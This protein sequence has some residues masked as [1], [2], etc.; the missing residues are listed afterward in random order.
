MIQLVVNN[1]FLDLYDTDPIK[2]NFSIED[3]ENFTTKSTFSRSFRVPAT[4]KNNEVFVNAFE[5]NGIDFDVTVKLSAQILFNG[6]EF[7]RGQIRLNSI[8]S[9]RDGENVDYELLFLGETRDFLSAVGSGYLRELN[10]SA[11]THT[12]SISG[13]SSSWQAYPQNTGFTSGYFNGDILYPL[14]DFGN[15][16]DGDGDILDSRIS[17]NNTGEHFTQNNHPINLNRFKPMIRAKALIDRIFTEAGFTYESN[18]LTGSTFRNLYVSAFG[19]TNTNTN[20]GTLNNVIAYTDSNIG[21][22]SWLNVPFNNEQ[23][24]AANKFNGTIYDTPATGS[25]DFRWQLLGQATLSNPLTTGTLRIRVMKNGSPLNTYNKTI[26]AIPASNFGGWAFAVENTYSLTAGEDVYLEISGGTNIDSFTIYAGGLLT[27]EN[28]TNSISIAG[29]F[30]PQYKK[31]DFLKDIFTVFRLVVQP[32]KVLANHFIIEPWND[33][34]GTGNILDWT[35]KADISK[36]IVIEP[37]FYTQEQKLK[38]T[39]KDGDGDFLNVDNLN[40]VGETFGTLKADSFNELLTGERVIQLGFA[41]TPITQIERKNP[42]IGKTFIIPQIHN[43]ESQDNVTYPIKHLPI[44]PTTRLLYYNGLKDTDSVTWH[45]SDG[46]TTTGITNYP[47]VSYWEKYPSSAE[48]INL[49][50]QIENG[51]IVSS[52]NN[53]LIGTSIYNGFW[54][55]YIDLLYNKNSRRVTAYFILNDSDVRD[56]DFRDVVFFKN[57]YYLVEKIVDCVVGEKTA[58]KVQ[59]L[60]LNNFVVPTTGFVPPVPPSATP[61]PSV[62]SSQTPTPTVTPTITATPTITPTQT[63][64]Q[65]P[66]QTPTNTQ[67][68]T[69]TP[70]NTQTPTQTTSQTPTQT[71][72]QTPT[73]TIT[74]TP[75]I[76]PSTPSAGMLWNNNTDN[77]ENET[78]NWDTI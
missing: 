10:L 13:I 4:R 36:D 2:L 32:S 27:I 68:P 59:L 14:I 55:N 21:S 30:D 71:I 7:S 11:Y 52:A 58:T 64:T 40:F 57:A 22:I 16:Y 42:L 28:V 76:T 46:V 56:F 74:P 78:S 9:T 51:Y 47:M 72:T 48:T 31:V 63:A 60:K 12:Q 44:K 5:I 17:Q 39:Y 20:T 73:T 54:S 61:T 37:L 70:T 65:T 41:P 77:W 62:T 50:W 35:D 75:S 38:F 49:N 1:V 53:E 34:I 6:A 24:D 66:T 19:T 25:Y 8:Y 23:L 29:L 33:F 26:T 18:F 43:H 45:Y 67:T 3:I 69:Q 15:N